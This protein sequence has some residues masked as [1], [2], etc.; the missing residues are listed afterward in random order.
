MYIGFREKLTLVALGGIAL[1]SYGLFNWFGLG[2]RPADYGYKIEASRRTQSAELA[3][4]AVKD[5]STVASAVAGD[6]IQAAM[7]G[8]STSAI[9]TDPGSLRSKVTSTNP[10]FAGAIV[11][12][13][14]QAGV[15]TSDVVAI[16]YTG[17]FPAL[18]IA[19]IAAAETLGAEPI[20]VSSVGASTWGANDPDLTILDM[21]S[22]LVQ[23]GIIAH[24]S[25]EASI[26]GD[27]KARPMTSEG[28][29]LATD[30][31]K[32]NNV[33]LVFAKNVPESVDQHMATYR[34]LANGRPIKAFVNVGGGLA[35]KGFGAGFDPGLNAP[36][37]GGDVVSGGLIERMQ[38]EGVP[39]INLVDI[40]KLAAQYML[41]VNP[42]TT[43]AVGAGGLY[44]DWTQLRIVAGLLVAALAATFFFARFTVLAPAS[45]EAVDTYFG[46][47]PRTFRAWIRSFGVRLP[48]RMTP[49]EQPV[50]D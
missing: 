28:R 9:T 49:Q 5:N 29:K 6:D 2:A 23:K 46:T 24:R 16:S 13:L 41:P 17:S 38:N 19:T 31:M 11:S 30:A 34:R 1:L 50:E 22:L 32:R 15:G 12:M 20:V 37:L 33:P 25:V 47:A 8:L 21:E 42:P 35:S 14:R 40:K 43:P 3:I 18:D 4:G 27:F 10:N 44:R 36:S 7:I 45:E 39:A 26:G 48:S